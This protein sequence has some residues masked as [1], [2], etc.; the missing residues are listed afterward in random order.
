MTQSFGRSDFRTVASFAFLLSLTVIAGCARE[1]PRQEPVSV[2]GLRIGTYAQFEVV[3]GDT[4]RIPE[5]DRGIR[6]L[7]ID[8]EEVPRGPHAAEELAHLR[9]T[10]PEP[11]WEKQSGQ[12]FPIKM[13]SPFGYETS[14]WAKRWF[15]DVDSVRLER[16]SPDNVYGYFGRWLAY[17]F[18]KKNGQW[19]NY[20]VECVR[21]GYSPYS[22]KYGY[23]E[24][25][26]DQFVAAQKE[27]RRESRGIWNPARQHYPMYAER[28]AW[29]TERGDA[30]REFL[31]LRKNRSD[32]YFIGRDGEY[33]RL[34]LA[35]H[36]TVC[37]FGTLGRIP[38]AGRIPD[39]DMPH[40]KDIA[41]RIEF[42]GSANPAFLQQ[43][44]QGYV[45]VR[46]FVRQEG[47]QV[48]LRTRNAD[49][50]SLRPCP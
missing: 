35:S 34:A 17:V 42:T 37:V 43:F 50:V 36:D 21:L 48:V 45:Y 18:A 8:T 4:F 41:V 32:V 30:I 13:P 15:A 2:A 3:D 14:E 26:H 38:E 46:G 10:W 28:L 47:K 31:A 40:K 39:V 33:E 23:S 29:W 19:I 6:F 5:I 27:A 9:S 1:Q 49:S 20:N 11:Y 44:E 25:F 12:R 24:R 22:M 7:C 16:D